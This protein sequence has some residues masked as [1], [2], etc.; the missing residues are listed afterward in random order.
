[1][2]NQGV[3]WGIAIVDSTQ[4]DWM[5]VSRLGVCGGFFHLHEQ[6]LFSVWPR[7][8]GQIALVS[9]ISNRPIWYVLCGT[10]AATTGEVRDNITEKC[11]KRKVKK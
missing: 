6:M 5:K 4:I 9:S 7:R 10:V 3:V 11:K 2:A 1:M 8:Q